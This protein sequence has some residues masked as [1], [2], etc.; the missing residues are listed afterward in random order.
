MQN[1]TSSGQGS[2]IYLNINPTY[3]H[4]NAS[5]ILYYAVV[6]S[7]FIDIQLVTF[8]YRG[9]EGLQFMELLNV[10]HTSVW[11]ALI[12]VL[13]PLIFVLKKFP[14]MRCN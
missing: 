14:E 2:D 9:F 10:F 12:S 11:L 6:T 1:L 7:A 8:V 3:V 5:A 13:V 4:L